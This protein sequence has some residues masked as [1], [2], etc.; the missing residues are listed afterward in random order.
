VDALAQ[1]VKAIVPDTLVSFQGWASDN[2]Y[3]PWLNHPELITTYEAAVQGAQV[4]IVDNGS[5]EASAKAIREMVERLKGIYIRNA[6]NKGYA[7]AN[8][9]GLEAA[10]GKS[11]SFSITI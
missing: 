7:A 1:A 2:H 9:Q 8:N 10:T 6:A 4:I 3:H 11:P 5:D